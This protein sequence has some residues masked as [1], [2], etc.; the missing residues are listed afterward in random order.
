[1]KEGKENKSIKSSSEEIDS[2]ISVLKL[3]VRGC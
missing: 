3:I 2:C 1:M